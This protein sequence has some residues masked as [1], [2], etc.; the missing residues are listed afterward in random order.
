MISTTYFAVILLSFLSVFTTIIG[1]ALAI[2]FKK[3][4]KGILVGIGFS[5]GIMLLISFFELIPESITSAGMSETLISVFLGVIFV[6]T[7]NL[8][9]PHTHLIKEKGKFD[10]S[11]LKSAYL[12]AFGLILHDFPEGFAMANSYIFSPSL[13]LLIALAIAI[14]NIPEEFA[15]AIPIVL[16]KKK[17]NFL[18]K[19]AFLSSIAEPAGAILGLFAVNFLPLLNPLFMSFAAGAMIFV[20]IHELFPMAKRYKRILFFILGIILSIFVYLGLTILIP[21]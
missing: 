14:H 18:F 12:V 20:S 2:V 1:V 9:I 15:M 7:L 21:E 16:T 19:I 8:I 13:G 5:A 10:S 11:L 3:G 4:V 17:K 6:G